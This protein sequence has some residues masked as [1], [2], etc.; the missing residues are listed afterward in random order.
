MGRP[1]ALLPFGPECL[2]Q[3]VVRLVGEAV[4]EIVV[5]A[6]P[7]QD[8]PELPPHVRI[9]FDQR[10]RRGPLEA[11]AAGLAALEGRAEAAFVTCCD[12]PNLSPAFVRRM[13]ELLGDAAVAVPWI[14]DR[15]HPLAAVY[16]MSV[17]PAIQSLLAA[18]RRQPLLLYDLVPTRRVTAQD[19]A[20]A[21]PSLASLE[22]LNRP[23][24]Y[25]QALRHLR[26]SSG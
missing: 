18:D 7:G 24:E 20:V 12:A 2:L 5:A 13:F 25:S 6:S 21:D 23:E 10:P 11:M 17:R 4:A 22:N 19:L 15:Y 26:L 9:V 16:R 14:G 8:L 1:K 3:R